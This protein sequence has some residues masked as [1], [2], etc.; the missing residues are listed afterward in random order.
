VDNDL[1]N[2]CKV[3]IEVNRTIAGKLNKFRK[4]RGTGL[5]FAIRVPRGASATDKKGGPVFYSKPAR[6]LPIFNPGWFRGG[7]TACAQQ[8][9]NNPPATPPSSVPR[10]TEGTCSANFLVVVLLREEE[11]SVDLLPFLAS[12]EASLKAPCLTDRSNN[13]IIALLIGLNE[14]G[15]E[16]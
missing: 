12:M 15:N 4:L 14:G 11:S 9:V 5:I 7:V 16:H 8:A 13:R 3:K 10:A 6:V 1:Q 2:S